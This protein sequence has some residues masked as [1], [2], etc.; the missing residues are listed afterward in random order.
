LAIGARTVHL[1][2]VGFK[3]SAVALSG[4]PPPLL[5]NAMRA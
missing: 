4:W 3:R 5:Q 1:A 2:L